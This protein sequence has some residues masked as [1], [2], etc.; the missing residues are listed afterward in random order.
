MQ[1]EKRYKY[2]GFITCLYITFQLVSDVSAGKLIDFFTFPVSVTV[3]FFPITYIFSDILTEVYGYANARNV[4]WTVMISS[5]LAGIIY[6]LVVALNPSK[7]FDANDAYTRVLG[8]VPRILI[9]GWLAV[10][11]G[12][13]TNNFILAKLKIVTRGKFLW[14]RTISSTIAG[15]LVNTSVFYI[16]GLYGVLPLNVL[17]TSIM[18]GWVIKVFVE[19]VFTPITYFVV[20]KLKTAEGVDF[21]D[22]HT[23]FNPFTFKP[24]F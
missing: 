23:N 11:A 13:I 5:I 9:G 16:I 24:P 4:L 18:S 20:A 10:F 22:K 21:Y 6:M 15:Q 19:I 2:L 8:Q 1:I 7:I 17:L 12:D 3:L 14:T